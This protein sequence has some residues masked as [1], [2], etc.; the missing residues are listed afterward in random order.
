MKRLIIILLCLLTVSSWLFAQETIVVGEVYDA[1]TGEPLSN[2]NIYLQ[3]TQEGTTTNAEGMFLLREELERARTMVVSAVGYHTERFTIE[4]HTQS[5]IDIA[6][7]EK[8]G[9]LAEVFVVPNENP[10]LALMEKVRARRAANRRM[11]AEDAAT[12]STALYVSDIQSRNLKRNLWKSLQSGMIQQEDSSYLVPL[13]WRQQTTDTVREE[14]TLLTV[15]DY[16]LLLGQIPSTF[17]FYAN[18]MP[19]LSTSMLSPLAASGNTYYTYFLVDSVWVG[20][21]KRYQVRFKTKNPFYATFNGEMMIDSA[22]CALRSIE[23]K[24]P[25]QTSINYLKGLSVRQ[26]FTADNQL[27]DE[28]VNM[29]MDFAVKAPLGND[30][31]HIFPTLLLTRGTKLQHEENTPQNYAPEQDDMILPAL[32]SLNNTP[33]FKTAKLLA[34]VVQTGC[35]PTSKYVEI[36][37]VHH[38]FKLSKFEG[39]RVGI[40]LRT[41]DDL[42]KN[43]CLEAMVAY[44]M[45]DRAWKGFGQINVALP[46]ERRHTMF[47][48]YADEYMYADVDDFSEYLRENIVFNKQINIVTRLMQSLTFNPDYYYNTMSRRREA[49]LQFSDEWNSYL[50]TQ[51][52]V[53]LGRMGYGEPTSRYNA[54]PSFSYSTIGASARIS[55]NERKVDTY[56]ERRHIY[57]H[58]PVIYL[59]AEMG[60]YR[61]DDMSSYRMYGNLQLMVRHDVDLG[62]GGELEYLVQ[63]GLVFGRVPYPLL[64]HFA[65]NQTHTF[66]PHR[67]SL[68]NNYQYAADQYVALQA[69]WN[70]KG[71]LFN[72]IPGVRYLR[73]RELV[74][75]KMAYGGLRQDHQQ[76]LAF[77]TTQTGHGTMRA[78]QVPYVEMGVGI[79]NILRIGEVYG[80]FRLTQIN[81]PAS[82]WWAVRFRLHL[83]M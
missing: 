29:L 78:M 55:F 56:F 19:F 64:Y 38:V 34:Y 76:V 46:T 24:M 59:G 57:N 71:V 82:P 80:V 74:E 60:S 63:A 69:H 79:G 17:D 32:D 48:R 30:T 47:V 23:V 28:Q 75:L 10:A 73:L 67:F 2:V 36:G 53:K 31:T 70:G 54:Q 44:G 13:Y 21:E 5:G 66:E 39:L 26:T 14:A 15:T 25:A 7:R 42:W 6:L 27:R 1:N 45:G 22:T 20:E 4:P 8:V 61:M 33:L 37:K 43:V 3:G 49:R 58:L 77:P 41:T 83:A 50:E 35:I 12:G 65:G 51:A 18:S 40:P 16:Q 52:Y 9:T 11:V 62:M 68:M 72:L 81:D